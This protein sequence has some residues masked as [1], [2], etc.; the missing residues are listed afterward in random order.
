MSMLS[1]RDGMPLPLLMTWRP[2]PHLKKQAETESQRACI[3]W[4]KTTCQVRV[5]GLHAPRTSNVE[6]TTGI[7]CHTAIVAKRCHTAPYS[8]PAQRRLFYTSLRRCGCCVCPRVTRGVIPGTIDT[9]AVL[10]RNA[11]HSCCLL[12][13]HTLAAATAIL[14][15]NSLYYEEFR[16]F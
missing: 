10:A 14:Q 12:A 15:V 9:A 11:L 1:R 16:K 13:E 7:E 3:R 8:T 6:N 5:V 4:R 2:Q